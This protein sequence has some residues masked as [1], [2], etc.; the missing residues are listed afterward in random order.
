MR[1]TYLPTSATAPG[2]LGFVG[3]LGGDFDSVPPEVDL[4]VVVQEEQNYEV[5]GTIGAHP[6]E[7]W[8]LLPDDERSAIR[9]LQAVGHQIATHVMAAKTVVLSGEH[10]PVQRVTMSVLEALGHDHQAALALLRDLGAAAR[11]EPR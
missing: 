3:P 1:V 9:A 11:P 2:R 10:D 8:F 6:E 4:L 7:V 5:P